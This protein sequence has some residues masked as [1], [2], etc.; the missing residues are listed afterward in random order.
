M[1]SLVDGTPHTDSSSLRTD[2]T[3]MQ[4]SKRIRASEDIRNAYSGEGALHSDRFVTLWVTTLF[5]QTVN[6]SLHDHELS[7][8]EGLGLLGLVIVV[9]FRANPVNEEILNGVAWSGDGVMKSVAATKLG[10]RLPSH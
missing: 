7:G 10:F 6:P 1:P 5:G 3:L 4:G 2:D 8:A 9:F